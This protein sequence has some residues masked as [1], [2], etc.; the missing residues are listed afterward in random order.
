MILSIG[1]FVQIQMKKKDAR[2]TDRED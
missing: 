1:I 2:I